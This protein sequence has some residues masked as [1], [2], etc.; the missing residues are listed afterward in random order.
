MG[1]RGVIYIYYKDHSG[2][3]RLTLFTRCDSRT[4]LLRIRREFMKLKSLKAL[5]KLMKD[6]EKDPNIEDI[7]GETSDLLSAKD[8]W[9]YLEYSLEVTILGGHIP[10]KHE[11]LTPEVELVHEVCHS[12]PKTGKMTQH[13]FF[14]PITGQRRQDRRTPQEK[15]QM[16]RDKMARGTLV[17]KKVVKKTKV[18]V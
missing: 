11:F 13:P 14:S 10:G 17:K 2:R 3:H 8:C 5:E 16:K 6:L 18:A 15:A 7:T 1:T 4:E 9:P 12:D